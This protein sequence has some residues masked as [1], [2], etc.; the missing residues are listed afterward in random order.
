MS[1]LFLC[2]FGDGPRWDNILLVPSYPSSYSYPRPFRYRDKWIQADL[3]NELSNKNKFKS[4]IGSQA[5]L[6]MRFLTEEHKWKLI[7]IRK[8]KITHID[9]LSDNNSV[10]FKLESF[11][12]YRSFSK[13]S[14]ACLEIDIEDYEKIGSSLFFKSNTIIP[15]NSFVNVDNED[16][17][18]IKFSD[19]VAREDILPI[20]EDAKRGLFLRFRKISNSDPAPVDVLYKSSYAGEISGSILSEGSTY[21]LVFFHRI[22]KLIDTNIDLKPLPVKYRASAGNIEFN[23][24]EEEFSSN[25]QTHVINITALRPSGTSEEIVIAPEQEE[26]N[27]QSKQQINIIKLAIPIKI[28][29]SN[30]YRFKTT[31]IW[32]LLLW[33]SLVANVIIGHIIE[34]KTNIPLII[35]SAIVSLFSAIAVF[36]MRKSPQ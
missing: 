24:S 13:L 6:C 31:G 27:N 4:F 30:Y 29:K 28:K 14:E 36:F 19:L 20:K 25:Y 26:T 11:R 32:L 10:Y 18:W 12:D 5:V 22:P 33:F 1:Q 2:F 23:R 17:N 16:A 3:L 15:E 7:P 35:G 21:E 9:M 8:V 34:G